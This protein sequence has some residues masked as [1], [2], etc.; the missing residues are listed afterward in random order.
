MH[1]N[2]NINSHYFTKTSQFLLDP[3]PFP[4]N[5]LNFHTRSIKKKKRKRS[6]SDRFPL[7]KPG[8]EK[9]ITSLAPTIDALTNRP[10]AR[11]PDD[12]RQLHAREIRVVHGGRLPGR[13]APDLGGQSAGRRG[14]LVRHLL[15]PGHLL[16][17]DPLRHDNPAA[18]QAQQGPDG[19]QLRL[20]HGLQDD[21]ARRR[22]RALQQSVCR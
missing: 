22:R 8:K 7:T 5:P 3:L 21:Q 11:F 9:I 2:Y 4:N 16:Q 19:L 6:K 17:R 12:V 15:G 1:K 13:L 14:P 10:D 18:P 20:S